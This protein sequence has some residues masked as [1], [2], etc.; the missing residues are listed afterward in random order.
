M[1]K[2]SQQFAE[3]IKFEEVINARTVQVILWHL[4]HNIFH[5]NNIGSIFRRRNVTLNLINK[6]PYKTALINVNK[7]LL[8]KKE[9]V[10]VHLFNMNAVL[11][12]CFILLY[13]KEMN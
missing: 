10:M 5:S 3:R 6:E 9:R 7:D 13:S 2:F 4:E 8:T 11:T 1:N 12:F